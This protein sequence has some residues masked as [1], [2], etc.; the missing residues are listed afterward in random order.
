VSLLS[1]FLALQ[2]SRD[3][4]VDADVAGDKEAVFGDL[5]KGTFVPN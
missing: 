2:L 4:P 3:V 5:I 1:C